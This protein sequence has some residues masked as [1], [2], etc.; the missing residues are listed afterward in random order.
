M[1]RDWPDFFIAA[2]ILIS[3]TCVVVFFAG[4]YERKPLLL[5]EMCGPAV[6]IVTDPNDQPNLYRVQVLRAVSADHRS[7]WLETFASHTERDAQDVCRQACPSAGLCDT[8]AG[9]WP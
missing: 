6:R 3:A 9:G 5:V 8:Y 7:I 1:F 4:S 2:L